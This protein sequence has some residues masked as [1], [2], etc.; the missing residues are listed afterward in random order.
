MNK[1]KL[2][3][4][5]VLFLIVAVLAVVLEICAFN[6]KPVTVKLG[7]RQDET[8]LYQA[9]ALAAD[10]FVG[11]ILNQNGEIELT[12]PEASFTLANLN[13][14]LNTLRT[15]YVSD[16]ISSMSAFCD[17]DK[18]DKTVTVKNDGKNVY[19]DGNI[20]SVRFEVKGQAGDKIAGIR[21]V[22]NDY[23]FDFSFSHV[24]AMLV[25]CFVT[26]G[27]FALQRPIDYGLDVNAPKE[28]TP[29]HKDCGEESQA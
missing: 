26:R 19:V 14:E 5:I 23:Q 27:L 2:A 16:T 22:I 6:F 25:I 28:E 21:F 9:D 7:W 18:E 17:S 10:S 3:E 24:I 1:H 4:E 11:C 20:L 13:F 29:Q 15:E 12:A 8:R